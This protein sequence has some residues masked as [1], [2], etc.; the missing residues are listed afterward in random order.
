MD[1]TQLRKY[2]IDHLNINVAVK[3]P[4]GYIEISLLLD[5]ELID[6]DYFDGGDIKDILNEV[7]K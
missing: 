4:E 1:E 2:L 6:Y 3:F 7:D 5:K